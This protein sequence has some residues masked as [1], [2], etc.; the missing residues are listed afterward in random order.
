MYDSYQK[1]SLNSIFGVLNLNYALIFV[2]IN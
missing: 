1:T 2:K